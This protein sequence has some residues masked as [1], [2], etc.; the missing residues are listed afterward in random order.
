MIVEVGTL[1]YPRHVTEE[2][3]LL[4]RALGAAGDVYLFLDY[5]GTLVSGPRGAALTPRGS[6]LRRLVQLSE[7]ESFS[8]YIMSGR[9]VE[10]LQHLVGVPSIGYI[11]QRGFEIATPGRPVVY[12]VDGEAAALVLHHVELEAHG[13][14]GSLPRIELEN[15][16]YGLVLH[17]A[18]AERSVVNQAVQQFTDTIRRVDT[19]STLE[20]LYGDGVVEA[21]MA[22]WGKGDAIMHVL[23]EAD[24]GS[25]LAIYIG[26]DVT[27][28]DAFEAIAVWAE[29]AESEIPWF[30]AGDEEDDIPA[31]L[32]ILVAEKPRPTGAELFVRSPQ[33]VHEFLASLSAIAS[34]LL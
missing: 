32:S 22:G 28:E 15:R 1:E 31:A 13:L 25:A 5:D 12:P 18:L 26:D 19:A 14:L 6:V 23:R 29:A 24:V 30:A 17:T 20:V 2:V 27:D 10:E 21:R 33:E 9:S 16:G 34:T 4:S 3:D 8:V 7:V 11:G